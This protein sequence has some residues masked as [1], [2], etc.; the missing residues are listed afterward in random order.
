MHKVHLREASDLEAYAHVVDRF[1]DPEQSSVLPAAVPVVTK[2]PG[3]PASREEMHA[4][5]RALKDT[6]QFHGML[7]KLN[8][9]RLDALGMADSD[10]AWR[11]DLEGTA[12]MLHGAVAIGLPI[13]A[14][15]GSPGCIQIHSGP[16]HNV[17]PMGPWINIFDDS[18]HLHLRLDQIVELWAVRKPTKDGHVTSVEA[19]AADRSLVIQFFGEREEGTDERR[20]WRDLA[21]SLAPLAAAR[22]LAGV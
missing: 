18:F 7:R 6:H 4:A 9:H 16:I 2:E 13:M 17:S 22:Q 15:V 1:R 19:Y 10:L 5:W 21:E 3:V 14:F 8:L 20:P 11:L 12:K